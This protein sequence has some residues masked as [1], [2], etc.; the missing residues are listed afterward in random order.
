M[1]YISTRG[2]TRPHS[3][4]EAVEAGLAT[5]GGLFLPE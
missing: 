4:T 5:D 3:F 2:Q 1:F